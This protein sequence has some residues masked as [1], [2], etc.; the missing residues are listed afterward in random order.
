MYIQPFKNISFFVS[1]NNTALVTSNWSLLF[2]KRTG[3]HMS[4]LRH[5][6]LTPLP[7]RDRSPQPGDTEPLGDCEE[8]DQRAG[9][10]H[11]QA[12]LYCLYY[13]LVDWASWNKYLLKKSWDHEMYFKMKTAEMLTVKNMVHWAFGRNQEFPCSYSFA[14]GD[15]AEYEAVNEL[16]REH[17]VVFLAR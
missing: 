3:W 16:C 2:K 9:Q 5:W 12:I 14:D 13:R 10:G 1:W 17:G 6:S 4:S 7:S 8:R 15:R 11:Y